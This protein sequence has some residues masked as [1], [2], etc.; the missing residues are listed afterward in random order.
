MAGKIFAIIAAAGSGKR[1][2][3]NENKALIPIAGKAMFLWSLKI[4]AN[5]KEIN[6]IVIAISKEKNKFEELIQKEKLKK[7]IKLIYGGE[8]RQES[9]NKA[10]NALEVDEEDY[11]LVHDAARPFVSIKL[12]NDIINELK[13]NDIIIPVIEAT[14]TLKEMEGEF[15]VKTLNRNKIKLTQTPQAFKFYYYKKAME[16]LNF[17]NIEFTDEASLF[18]PLNFKI[19]TIKGDRLNIKITYKEDLEIAEFIA[20]RRINKC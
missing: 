6:S 20:A 11:I 9:V 19:K 5:T 16:M 4:F 18:E 1:L 10:I 13:K 14:D 15:I 7:D 2:G 17:K 3:L 12:I 8:S